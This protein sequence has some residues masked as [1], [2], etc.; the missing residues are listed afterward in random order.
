M[1]HKIPYLKLQ[2]KPSSP[3]AP[4]SPP[5]SLPQPDSKPPTRT[6]KPIIT[7]S[8]LNQLK[9]AF[10]QVKTTLNN[11]QNK[12]KTI[13]LPRTQPIKISPKSHHSWPKDYSLTDWVFGIGSRDFTGL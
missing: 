12:R 5:K 7:K 4:N 2:P 8:K 10:A 3:T 6:S 1:L 13:N 9:F 11:I